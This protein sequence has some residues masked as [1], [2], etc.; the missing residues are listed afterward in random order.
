MPRMLNNKLINEVLD[1]SRE[2]VKGK[3]RHKK[4]GIPKVELLGLIILGGIIFLALVQVFFTPGAF[5]QV[6][7][8]TVSESIY[9]SLF[10]LTFMCK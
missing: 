7:N 5:S 2:L 1:C 10:F 8:R 3:C 4:S 9:L 6:L